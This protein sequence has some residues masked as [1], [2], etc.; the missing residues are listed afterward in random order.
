MWKRFPEGR[1]EEGVLQ[2]MLDAVF[3][4]GHK[5]FCGFLDRGFVPAYIFMYALAGNAGPCKRED[6]FGGDENQKLP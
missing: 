6:G 5:V 4:P 3:S 1:R 2:P